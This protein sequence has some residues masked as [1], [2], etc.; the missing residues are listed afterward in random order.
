MKARP[1]GGHD[2]ASSC[3]LEGGLQT[4]DWKVKERKSSI[5]L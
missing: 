3:L 4:A 5:V 1:V 2:R